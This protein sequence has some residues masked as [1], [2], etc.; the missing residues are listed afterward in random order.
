MYA[1]AGLRVVMVVVNKVRQRN[2]RSSL[3]QQSMKLL[4]GLKKRSSSRHGKAF[5]RRGRPESARLP[6]VEVPVGHVGDGETGIR[7]GAR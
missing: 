1:G 3:C 7:P 2:R 5:W 4:Q 6:V